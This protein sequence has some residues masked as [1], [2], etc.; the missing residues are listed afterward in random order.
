MANSKFIKFCGSGLLLSLVPL[1]PIQAGQQPVDPAFIHNSTTTWVVAVGHD[2]GR[3]W[4]LDHYRQAKAQKARRYANQ[5]SAQVHSAWRLGCRV[6][7]PRWSRDWDDH[8]RW[9]LHA[10]PRKLHREIERRERHLQ[11]CRASHRFG[12]D[13][14][15]RNGRWP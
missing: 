8:F 3:D 15:L 6:S 9:A 11:E 12:W 5:A 1:M 7:G 2:R 4:R 13:H 10:H 14:G